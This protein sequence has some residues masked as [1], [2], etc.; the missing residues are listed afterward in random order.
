[1]TKQEFRSKLKH[2]AGLC[3]ALSCDL[4]NSMD[5]EKELEAEIQ[6]YIDHIATGRKLPRALREKI[7]AKFRR[8]DED[9]NRRSEAMKA[10]W[11]RR[12]AAQKEGCDVAPKK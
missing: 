10:A 4:A 7:P 6:L 1:M 2:I 12:K 11:A 5:R 8:G 3:W 9:R